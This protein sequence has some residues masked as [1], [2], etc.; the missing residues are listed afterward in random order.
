MRTKL[1]TGLA[2]VIAATTIDVTG[3]I[4]IAFRNTSVAQVKKH[5]KVTLSSST[6]GVVVTNAVATA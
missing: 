5:L 4:Q 1:L 2:A 6:P 3:G